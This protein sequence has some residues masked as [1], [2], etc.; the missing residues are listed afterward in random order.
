MF[1]LNQ[2]GLAE[3]AMQSVQNV[4]PDLRPL[5]LNNVVCCGGTLKCPG[6]SARLAADMQCLAPA[7]LPVGP[8]SSAKTPTGPKFEQNKNLEYQQVAQSGLHHHCLSC[9]CALIDFSP[10]YINDLLGVGKI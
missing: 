3:A 1:G 6:L 2:A 4:H 7:G 5:L 8:L 9:A 10:S